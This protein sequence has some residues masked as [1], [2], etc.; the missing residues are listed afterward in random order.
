[1]NSERRKMSWHFWVPHLI[2][3][4]LYVVMG[5]YSV[6]VYSARMSALEKSVEHMS[7]QVEYLTTHVEWRK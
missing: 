4:I 1:M 2:G 3:G 7:G 6:G 5:I